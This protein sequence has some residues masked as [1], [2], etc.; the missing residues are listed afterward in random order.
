MN[1]EIISS[2]CRFIAL[3]RDMTSSRVGPPVMEYFR[4]PIA[5]SFER[6]TAA[7]TDIRTESLSDENSD[8]SEAPPLIH[9]THGPHPITP[10][11]ACMETSIPTEGHACCPLCLTTFGSSG[12]VSITRLSCGTS[13]VVYEYTTRNLATHVGHVAHYVCAFTLQYASDSHICPKCLVPLDWACLKTVFWTG[14]ESCQ[15]HTR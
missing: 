7:R 11:E 2:Y 3:Q 9:D 8:G 10:T 14:V 1:D 4:R 13:L 15:D 6:S 12:Q 5:Y